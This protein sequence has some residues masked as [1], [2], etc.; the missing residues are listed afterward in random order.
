[1]VTNK[2]REHENQSDVCSRNV[3]ENVISDTTTRI[4]DACSQLTRDRKRYRTCYNTRV[5]Q[6]FQKKVAS[7]IHVQ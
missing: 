3:L 4:N 1:M 6:L 5:L 2:T 7:V